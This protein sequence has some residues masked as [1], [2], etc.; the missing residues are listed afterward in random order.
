MCVYIA[1]SLLQR[2]YTSEEHTKKLQNIE[3]ERQWYIRRY[4]RCAA[5]F[6]VFVNCNIET[7]MRYLKSIKIT[8]HN[9]CTMIQ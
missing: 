1:A 3:K 9:Q 6:C 8:T 4:V 7:L 2:W 5:V